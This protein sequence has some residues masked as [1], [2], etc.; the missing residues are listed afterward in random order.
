MT[1]IVNVNGQ[2]LT[3]PATNPLYNWGTS[4]GGEHLI[5]YATFGT[6]TYA[7][8]YVL[9]TGS[10]G[11]ATANGTNTAYWGNST[12][13]TNGNTFYLGYGTG[14]LWYQGD[15]AVST[16]SLTDSNGLSPF[17][18]AN[19][20]FGVI[21]NSSYGTNWNNSINSNPPAAP[22]TA[23][24]FGT[25]GAGLLQTSA[26]GGLLS[27]VLGQIPINTNSLDQGYIIHSGGTSSTNATLTIGVD[28]SLNGFQSLVQMNPSTNTITTSTGQSVKIYP[29]SQLTA[30]I[31]LVNSQGLRFSTNISVIVD[32]GGLKGGVENS[33]SGNNFTIPTNFISNGHLATG[34]NFSLTVAGT[35]GAQGLDWSYTAG[36][37]AYTNKL[38]I[39]S[40]SVG[41]INTGITIY[42][43][44][45]VMFDTTQGVMGFN[46]L[47][48]ELNNTTQAYQSSYLYQGSGSFTNSLGTNIGQIQWTGGGGF[49]A[50]GGNLTVNLGGLS[51]PLIWGQTTNF[52]GD[53]NSLYFSSPTSDGTVILQNGIDLH[54]SNQ[55]ILVTQGISS[56]TPG[57]NITGNISNGGLK[58]GDAT[59]IGL[60]VLSGTN[61]Y[62]GNTTINGGTL[63]F[64]QIISMPASGT[65]TVNSN[66]T[67]AVNVG[68]TGQFTSSTSGNGSIG[69]LFSGLGGQSG[70][71]VTLNPGSSIGI[72][73]T[74]AGG[75]LTY[76]GSISNAGVGLTKLG[77]GT[78]LLTH[79]NTYS[80]GTTLIGGVLQVANEAKIGGAGGGGI[81]LNGGELLTTDTNVT[82]TQNV[83]VI[84]IA[85][86][87][88]AAA[89]NTTATYSGG[90]ADGASGSGSLS[91]ND[92]TNN[93]TIVFSGANT[94]SGDTIINT[95]TLK[96]GADRVFST[97][98]AT[99]VQSG[100]VLDLA[101][102]EERIGTLAG[103]GG[104]SLGSGTLT[105]GRDSEPASSFGGAISGA[106][107]FIKDG[108]NTQTLSGSNSYSGGTTIKKGTLQ[109]S[110][111]ASMPASGNVSVSSGGT[112]AVNAGGAGEFGIGT[113]GN[114]TIGGLLSG[115]GGQSGSTVTLNSG[116]A[117][118]IDTTDAGGSLTY[119][120]NITNA[121]VGLTK[122]GSGT[123]ALTASNSYS[124]PTTVTAGTLLANNTSGSALGS[125]TVTVQSGG[126]LGGNGTIGAA[127]SVEN[128]G[129][130]TA[131]S[132]GVGALTLT[133]GLT[134]NDKSTTTF[135]ITAT[136]NYTSLN[137]MG[138]LV[139]YG[140]TLSL[141]LTQYVPSAGDTFALFSTWGNGATNTLDFAA[142]K[143][144]GDTI[145]FT[146]SSGVWTGTNSTGVTYQFVDSTG[147]LSV[148]A[149]PEPC[150]YALFGVGA[151]TLLIVARRKQA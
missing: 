81:T 47:N 149:V 40:G 133:N 98:S 86:N 25:L 134:L 71:L 100:A 26:K 139:T 102:H 131:G 5:I 95:G 69:G 92:T 89:S 143:S 57:A 126:T 121:G 142:L 20:T 6:N 80:G 82:V 60:L 137:I 8:P 17:S 101:G 44:Y 4:S 104:V 76:A 78:L 49:S 116:S 64:A 146:K 123:L 96:A 19:A 124:G 127:V 23:Q 67:L 39:S 88:L 58:V 122:L 62:G 33:A 18:I 3:S 105:A 1:S 36:L 54:G 52:I 63:E 140:G 87:T 111:I 41:V 145:S 15:S 7:N 73:T 128:G 34:D 30:T 35:N 10:F 85:T 151:L 53:G 83:T 46:P 84:Q 109:F 72:D 51:S 70:S 148:Q 11:F 135:L 55:T 77:S 117:L 113:S 61:T 150:T 119:T 120:A 27:S 97:N 28:K 144:I 132:G 2:G 21:T 99:T 138:G 103:T 14:S 130:L 50:Q 91:I 93:G 112:L 68:G 22:E 48:I 56:D 129:S 136:N 118:G 13:T 106:G 32:S 108:S 107:A 94:Y 31:T 24:T 42:H 59:N 125:S 75:Y 12:F 74:D 9:D 37:D 16:V 29:E 66:A 147:Y 114:G 38:L 65:V 141:D 43:V 79:D 110:Q 45:D 115:L 90:I